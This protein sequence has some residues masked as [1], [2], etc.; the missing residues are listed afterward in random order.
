MG[1]GC[2]DDAQSTKL[3]QVLAAAGHVAVLRGVPLERVYLWV[4]YSVVDQDNPMPGVQALPI[5][6]A[7]SEE[8]VYIEHEAYWERA[9]CVHSRI[10]MIHV[11]AHVCLSCMHAWIYG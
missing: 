9:W 7:C 5:Y 3:R 11:C 10:I 6:V 8:F 4:D 1:N 2:P